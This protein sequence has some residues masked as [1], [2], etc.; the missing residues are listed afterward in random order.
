MELQ[1]ITNT[2]MQ[3]PSWVVTQ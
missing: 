2:M 3:S 1:L